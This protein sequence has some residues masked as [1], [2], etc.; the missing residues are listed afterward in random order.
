VSRLRKMQERLRPAQ[1]RQPWTNATGPGPTTYTFEDF[2]VTATAASTTITFAGTSQPED[3]AW[4]LDDVSVT[5]AAAVPEPPTLGLFASP[6]S[7]SLPFT[8]AARRN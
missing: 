4:L 8:V 6:L 3:G 5:A 2:T 1:V 7:A